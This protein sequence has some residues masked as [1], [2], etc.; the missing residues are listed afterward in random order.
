M[1]DAPSATDCWRWKGYRNPVSGYGQIT[2]NRTEQPAFGQ[3]TLTAPQLACTLVHGRRP[4]GK[5]V[6]HSCDERDCCNPVHLRWGTQAENNHEAWT[7]GN[8]RW[9]EE[10]PQAKVDDETVRKAV[11]RVRSGETATAVAADMGLS[12]STLCYW[13]RGKGRGRVAT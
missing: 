7:R 12:H 10:H 9:G 13:V 1:V 8:Q 11:T 3:R 6:L 5:Q 4:P 2:L